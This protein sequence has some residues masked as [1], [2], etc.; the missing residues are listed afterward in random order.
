MGK[1]DEAPSKQDQG[2]SEH[3][4][5]PFDPKKEH[6]PIVKRLIEEGRMPSLEEFLDAVAKVRPKYQRELRKLR[7]RQRKRN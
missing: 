7:E 2:P 6:L 5:G 1:E 3:K 4:E